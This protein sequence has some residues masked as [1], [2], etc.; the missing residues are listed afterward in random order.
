MISRRPIPSPGP[1]TRRRQHRPCSQKSLE[2]FD[3]IWVKIRTRH[4]FFLFISQN[5][6]VSW[7]CLLHYLVI[8]SKV[9]PKK[10]VLFS[11][12]FEPFI[13]RFQRPNNGINNDLI[14]KRPTNK[15]TI[16]LVAAAWDLLCWEVRIKI[17]IQ[18]CCTA[19]KVKNYVANL[20]GVVQWPRASFLLF[21]D[22][23]GTEMQKTNYHTE[24]L[25]N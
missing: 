7:E 15:E 2:L 25:E 23:S 5:L 17:R 4:F 16:E 18:Q 20:H 9:P 12:H 21:F 13:A 19:S 3:I 14:L 22:L 6:R 8:Q 1:K 24:Q 11:L 10:S